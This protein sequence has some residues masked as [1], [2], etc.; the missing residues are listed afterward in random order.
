MDT[1][2]IGEI[3]ALGSA[4]TI[5]GGAVMSRFLTFRIRPFIIQV[6][7]ALTGGVV[8]F[9]IIAASGDAGQYLHIP[10]QLIGMSML[11]TVGGIIIG[12]VIYM[13]ILSLAPASKAC[14][15]L[16]SLRILMVSI[17]SSIF[18]DEAI[19][20]FVVIAAVMIM[21]GVYLALSAEEAQHP[22]GIGGSAR[23]KKWLPLCIITAVLWSAYY[24]LMKYV[25]S[26][27]NAVVD[28]PALIFSSINT[29]VGAT[30]LVLFL[31]ARKE[32]EDL[33]VYR[34]GWRTLGIL[35]ANGILVYVM[36]M[37]ME[38]LALD[39]AGPAR[40]AILTSW[41]PIFVMILSGIFLKEKITWRL[42]VGTL[43][44][45]GGTIL[46]VMY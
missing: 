12:D 35:I 30:I 37:I 23:L 14:P 1:D 18:Y 38:L 45:T 26:E 3:F 29:T 8:L 5:G 43:L 34:A 25:M 22:Q 7:R 32:G 4:L 41:A 28:N 36:G 24:L 21:T 15:A 39:F 46:L 17:G 11:A 33:L 6:G 44:C 9:L 2:F 19:T 31:L 16:W 40:T 20:W 10:L 27:G 42:V 13:K